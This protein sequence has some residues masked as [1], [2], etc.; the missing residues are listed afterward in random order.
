MKISL[1]V[2]LQVIFN[3]MFINVLHMTLPLNTVNQEHTSGY[4]EV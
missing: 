2:D 1:G 4:C 3:I